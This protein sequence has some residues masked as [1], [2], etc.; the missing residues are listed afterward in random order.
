MIEEYSTTVTDQR[1]GTSSE[2][3]LASN[4]NT[5]AII[6][7]TSGVILLLLLVAIIIITVLILYGVSKRKKCVRD[8]SAS[9]R[10]T[11]TQLAM[12]ERSCYKVTVIFFHYSIQNEQV[13]NVTFHHG[14]NTHNRNR[15]NQNSISVAEIQYGGLRFKTNTGTETNMQ[16]SIDGVSEYSHLRH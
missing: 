6:A 2:H 7:G 9:V 4:N 11:K 15:D 10:Y 3:A 12:H 5:E 16:D 8:D 13:Y 14:V 1:H